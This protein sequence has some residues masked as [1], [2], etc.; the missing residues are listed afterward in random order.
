M[1]LAEVLFSEIIPELAM[2]ISLK[3]KLSTLLLLPVE[4]LTLEVAILESK[5]LS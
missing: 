3:S 2:I 5:S 4:Y 1:Y